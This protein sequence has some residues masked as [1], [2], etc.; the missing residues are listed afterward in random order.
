MKKIKK[1]M[2]L[3]LAVVFV[4]VLFPMSALA[5]E[6]GNTAGLFGG[7]A[8]NVA[9]NSIEFIRFISGLFTG[10][11]AGNGEDAAVKKDAEGL[12]SPEPVNSPEENGMKTESTA[13]ADSVPNGPISWAGI[14]GGLGSGAENMISAITNALS[15]RS[16]LS[17]SSLTDLIT[18]MLSL[19][20]SPERTVE[21]LSNIGEIN[22]L[23]DW[24]II[25]LANSN[26]NVIPVVIDYANNV[27]NPNVAVG[28]S[29]L[30]NLQNETGLDWNTMM[31]KINSIMSEFGLDFEGLKDKVET[32]KGLF[33]GFGFD[34]FIK[35][36][37]GL[38]GNLMPK[39]PGTQ[40]PPPPPPPPSDKPS[41][42][43]PASPPASPGKP[44]TVPGATT[45]GGLGSPKTGDMDDVIINTALLLMALISG[46]G[47][48]LLL[49]P[50]KHAVCAETAAA[51]AAV[52]TVSARAGKKAGMSSRD[53][54]AGTDCVASL[55]GLKRKSMK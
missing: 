37:M 39:L 3:F 51:A 19:G 23:T 27:G 7:I 32:Y 21:I 36:L 52:K 34:P 28:L 13:S 26:I 24:D 18:N 12:A 30:R 49:R 14:L 11:E 53:G 17:S 16:S 33:G 47:I 4:S 44:N 50:K 54:C 46:V 38:A 20:I 5:N 31:G 1:G 8:R 22:L 29:W 15:G 42:D 6:A 25:D 10:E 45:P 2:C 35:W 41:L 55:G 48:A 43:P 40:T 9:D